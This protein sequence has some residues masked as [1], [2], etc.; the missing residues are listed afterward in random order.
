MV[1]IYLDITAVDCV[2]SSWE[3][4]ES[5]CQDKYTPY[6]ELFLTRQRKRTEKKF[7][8]KECVGN[9]TEVAPW[10][11]VCKGSLGSNTLYITY[12]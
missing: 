1:F 9:S 2:W 8:G 10:R 7:T 3:S 12:T 11:S 5:K 6:D 4:W